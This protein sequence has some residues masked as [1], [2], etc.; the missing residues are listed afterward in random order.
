MQAN[1]PVRPREI[2][3]QHTWLDL[4]E[5][6]EL[7]KPYIILVDLMTRKV[8]RIVSRI[9]P[10]T[11]KI[12]N[13]F[14]DYHFFPNPEGFYSY[15]FGLLLEGPNEAINS[16]INQTIDG[17]TLSNTKGGLVSKKAG[18]KRGSLK[19]GMGEFKQ[20]N[21]SGDD[22]RK[23]IMPL[24]FP[25]P[26]QVL[27]SLIGMLQGYV[28]SLTSV[29]EITTG[30]MPPSDT[31]ATSISILVQ[32]GEKIFTSIHKRTHESFKSELEKIFELDNLYVD[33]DDYF[34]VT[35]NKD[36]LIAPDGNPIPEGVVKTNLKQDFSR[37]L[38]IQPVSDPNIS[39]K[40]E[41]IA[42]AQTL[43]QT[44]LSNPLTLENQNSIFVATLNLFKEIG[45][46]DGLIQAV[47]Q[48][49]PPPPPPPNLSQI[50]ENTLFFNEKPVD[51]L[52]EQ[53]HQEHIAII[54]SLRE[55]PLFA[56]MSSAGK[57]MLEKH[58]LQHLGFLSAQ[59]LQQE[60][61]DLQKEQGV[62]EAQEAQQELL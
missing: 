12:M 58:R 41:R 37:D 61:D 50:E 38:I 2:L 1:D 44:I 26:S 8:L 30:Q 59:Q 32:E 54:D 29:S 62:A 31:T 47:L 43:Y 22:L 15:G 13:F 28:N 39:S 9:N 16:M 24:E 48:P 49:P 56:E 45:F 53:D 33:M 23:S 36:Q 6:G 5:K 18:M 10:Q 40:G 51:A 19:F 55:S 20:V 57:K 3:E 46:E 7:K 17:G 11:K 52:E 25:P 42:K 14:T 4:E 60:D 34:K 27:L 35:I 21:L